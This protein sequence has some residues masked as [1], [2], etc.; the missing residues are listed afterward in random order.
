[1][2]RTWLYGAIIVVALAVIA[3]GWY[4]QNRTNNKMSRTYKVV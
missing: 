1:M 4:R 3:Y 2:K